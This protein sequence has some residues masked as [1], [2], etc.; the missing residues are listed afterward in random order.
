[1]PIIGFAVLKKKICKNTRRHLN[2]FYRLLYVI[3]LLKWRTMPSSYNE[4]KSVL[5]ASNASMYKQKAKQKQLR[6]LYEPRSGWGVVVFVLFI[7]RLSRN[8]LRLIN[9][10]FNY[11]KKIIYFS[12]IKQEKNHYSHFTAQWSHFALANADMT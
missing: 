6:T 4:W 8:N 7:H 2:V 11:R 10:R 12:N 3:L 9:K 1:M 5:R